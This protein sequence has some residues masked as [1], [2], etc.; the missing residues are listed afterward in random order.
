ML[1][2]IVSAL[3]VAPIAGEGAGGVATVP[4][5]GAQASADVASRAK[6]ARDSNRIIDG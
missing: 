1:A 5:D 6:S 2:G 3:A 4:A